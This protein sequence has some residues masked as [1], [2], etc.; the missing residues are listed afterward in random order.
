[1]LRREISN[2]PPGF[3]IEATLK[4]LFCSLE[5]HIDENNFVAMQGSILYDVFIS[6]SPVAASVVALLG[7]GLN[8][9]AFYL[10]YIHSVEIYPTPVRNSCTSLGSA[11]GRM[12][13]LLSPYIA[14][15]GRLCYNNTFFIC[16][17]NFFRR[18][19]EKSYKIKFCFVKRFYFEHLSLFKFLHASAGVNFKSLQ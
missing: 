4:K 13:A 18:I 12:G 19:L 9:G 17:I 7:K 2:S 1:M 10:V 14:Y 11:V 3:A 16:V 6:A 15:L 5:Q 8:S